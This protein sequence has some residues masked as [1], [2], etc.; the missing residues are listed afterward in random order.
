VENARLLTISTFSR[1]VGIPASALRHYASEGILEP[2]DV[3]SFSG[4]RYYAP[5]QIVT[6]VVVRDL[7]TADVPLTLMR[8]ILAADN[9]RAVEL[10]DEHREHQATSNR[11][12][13]RAL[14]GAQVSL[15][16]GHTPARARVSG[17]VLAD[18]LDQ[19]LA[20]SRHAAD[21][22]DGMVWT[23]SAGEVTLMATDRYWLAQRRIPASDAVTGARMVTSSAA[24]EPLAG[25]VGRER[26]VDVVCTGN[27]VQLSAADGAA[28]ADCP[29]VQRD[30][31]DLG[32][33]V[34]SQPPAQVLIGLPRRELLAKL[35]TAADEP[36]RIS[37]SAST[38]ELDGLCGWASGPGTA[39]VDLRPSLLAEAIRICPEGEILLGLVDGATPVTVRSSVQ[40]SLVC[41]VM[42]MRL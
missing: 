14:R 26:A 3:D 10:L 32:R 18:S 1:A 28:L 7:R 12:R 27:S 9:A 41:L 13:D 22:V 5:E 40:D 4:Y 20:A 2:A 42:P 36:I 39:E 30:I 8:E 29:V 33:L 21:E 38:V 25:A 35:E 23:V 11:E 24:T 37:A 16:G 19:V 34:T 31:P 17:P 15:A 6:G